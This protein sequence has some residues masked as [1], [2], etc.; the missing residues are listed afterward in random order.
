MIERFNV[1][2]GIRSRRA[3]DWRLVYQNDIRNPF[4]SVFDHAGI[5][6]GIGSLE[7]ALNGFKQA[8]MDQRRV[9]RAGDAGD[10][11]HHAERNVDVDILEI[12]FRRFSELQH[13]RSRSAALLWNWNLE[14]PE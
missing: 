3:A 11:C 8:L 2:H 10:A 14:L 5:Q 1:R 4:H 12:M 9:S 7:R 6:T 13:R